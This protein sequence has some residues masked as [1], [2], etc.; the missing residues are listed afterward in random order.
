MLAALL[1]GG[2][3][4]RGWPSKEPVYKG[5]GVREYLYTFRH[6]YSRSHDGQVRILPEVPEADEA[7]RF[8]GTNLVPYI[9]A[10]LRARDSWE[11][12]ALVWVSHKAPW[13]RFR[14]WPANSLH[15][16]GICTYHTILQQGYWGDAQ[17]ACESEVH[18]LT[19]DPKVGVI[20]S[21]VLAEIHNKGATRQFP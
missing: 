7:Y 10:C 19:N 14:V 21:S 3:V 18:A 11:R 12:R 15:L 2:V 1:I 8:F 20:A 4:W 5:K 16:A 9:R 13:L 17:A 6:S